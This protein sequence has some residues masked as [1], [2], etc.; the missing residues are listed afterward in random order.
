MAMRDGWPKFVSAVS[1]SDVVDGRRERRHE[2]GV[3]IDG[4]TDRIVTENLSM[5]HSPRLANGNSGC[6]IPDADISAVLM[7]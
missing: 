2:G 7:K 6:S 3:I 1:R 4:E 5:P